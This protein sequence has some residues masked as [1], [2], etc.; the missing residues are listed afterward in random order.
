MI[1]IF[2]HFH[3]KKRIWVSLSSFNCYSTFEELFACDFVCCFLWRYLM[4]WLK[5]CIFNGLWK[6]AFEC[7]INGSINRWCCN[8]V[9]FDSWQTEVATL[10]CFCFCEKL[11][12]IANRLECVS[13]KR[14]IWK[15]F[16]IESGTTENRLGVR[17]ILR[18]KNK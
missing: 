3:K 8:Y 17:R 5:L 12:F 1:F 2:T 13:A 6:G 16:H 14:V 11:L 4:V 9:R 18:S 7:R 10:F 15:V